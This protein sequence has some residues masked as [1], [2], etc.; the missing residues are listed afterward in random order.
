MP[1]LSGA[2]SKLRCATLALLL[3]AVTFA[4]CSGRNEFD[5][6]LGTA[7]EPYRFDVLRWELKHAFERSFAPAADGRPLGVEEER[8]VVER[9]FELGGQLRWLGWER[10][11]GSEMGQGASQQTLEEGRESLLLERERLRP[12]VQWILGRQVRE[13]YNDQGIFNPLDRFFGFSVAFPPMNFRLARPPLILV[14]SPRERIESIREV[15]LVENMTT[16]SMEQLEAQVDA[17]GVSS[18]IVEIGGLGATY[19]TFVADDST[20]SWTVQ[21]VAEEWLH[22]YLFFTPLGFRYALDGLGIR[23]DYDIA[24]MNET[25]AGIVSS[26]IADQVL[27]TYYGVEGGVPEPA[28]PA[29]M[30]APPEPERFDYYREMREI[31]LKVDSLL[32]EGLVGEAERFMEERRLYLASEGYFIRKLNQAYFAFHG[33]YGDAPTSVSPI[34]VDMRVLR[35]R[36]VRDKAPSLRDFLNQVASMRSVQDLEEAAR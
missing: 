27:S 2:L 26:E 16:D 25:V 19:P 7:V 10:Q 36:I 35:E 3:L 14:V 18:L 29:E 9:F 30:Q 24:T 33:T 31:R 32:A 6:R 20:L 17:L 1:T 8:L 22:Q 21:T 15:M 11:V 12:A 34:G 13:V 4:G 23:R 5:R 28:A